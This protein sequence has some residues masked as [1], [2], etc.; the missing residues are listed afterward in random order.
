MV[1]EISDWSHVYNASVNSGMN[2]TGSINRWYPILEGFSNDFVNN[3]LKEQNKKPRLCL[4][5][6]AGGGTTPLEMQLHGVKCIS[7][8]VSPFMS[9]V[10]RAK[11]KSE[12]KRSELQEIIFKMQKY[13]SEKSK[14][15]FNIGLK[16]IKKRKSKD[17][18]YLFFPTAYNSLLCIRKAIDE[19]ATEKYKDLL[20]VLLGSLLL[21]YCN[22]A[23]DGKALRYKDDWEKRFHKRKVIYSEFFEKCIELALPDVSIIERQFPHKINNFD[24]FYSG[25]CRNLINKV[26]NNSVDLVIT[27]PPYLNSRDYTDSHMVELWMLGHVQSYEDVSNLRKKTVRSHVQVN[28][29]KY[30]L[31]ESRVLK[32]AF[33]K[34]LEFEDVFW[35]KNIPSMIAGYFTDMEI[36][37][38]QLILKMKSGG[39]LYINVANSSYFG[40]IVETDLIIAEIAELMG[41]ELI[42]IRFARNIKTSSQQNA[43]I[44]ALRESVIVLQS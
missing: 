37:L 44:K 13:L 2:K 24:H 15:G 4:D 29:G 27:S 14:H 31:P 3:I 22:A 21:K 7:F 23:R 19:V 9:Q 1:E 20:Y 40:V 35:N 11:L 17:K 8:E 26:E 12:Y 32:E 30:S 34:I 25:D 16:T 6:F 42:D 33:E 18:K 10:C 5:P 39:K 43:K 41:Y 36:L 28:W 38:K